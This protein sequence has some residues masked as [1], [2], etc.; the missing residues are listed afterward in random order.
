[1]KGDIILNEILI[2]ILPSIG[3]VC[4]LYTLVRYYFNNLNEKVNDL[5]LKVENLENKLKQ[6]N[7][8]ADYKEN[9]Q[10]NK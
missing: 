9:G 2:N 6:M 5:N 3:L 10:E 8:Y 1:M 4:A 7:Q